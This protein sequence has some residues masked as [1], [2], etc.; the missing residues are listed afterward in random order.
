ML[1]DS[2]DSRDLGFRGLGSQGTKLVSDK[3]KPKTFDQNFRSKFRDP[4]LLQFA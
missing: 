3:L 2:R 1:V 4:N